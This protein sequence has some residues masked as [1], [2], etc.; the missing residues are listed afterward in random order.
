MEIWKIVLIAVCAAVAFIVLLL[1]LF[2]V[3]V[4]KIA[5]GKRADKN[6]LLKYF[7]SK[8]FGLSCEPV[9]IND[10]KTTLH[11]YIY[12]KQVTSNKLIIFCHGMGPGHI[13][14]TTEVN[15]FCSCGYT[16]IAVD[17][18]GCNFSD[19]KNI[20]GMYSGVRGVKAA[21]DFARGNDKL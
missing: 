9:S 19:G 2:A 7:T 6:P 4:D 17:Y 18:R 5:F 20:R 14:Y 8:D 10:A 11:G 12:K 13:A 16:V 1:L 21:I 3:I 15:Y